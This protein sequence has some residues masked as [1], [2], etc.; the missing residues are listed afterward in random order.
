MQGRGVAI[1]NSRN[2]KCN[3][4]TGSPHHCDLNALHCMSV[5]FNKSP[6]TYILSKFSEQVLQ[7]RMYMV[8][9]ERGGRGWNGGWMCMVTAVFGTNS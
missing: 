2:R 7:T 8:G 4:V 1:G 3:D 6:E 9:M 5:I